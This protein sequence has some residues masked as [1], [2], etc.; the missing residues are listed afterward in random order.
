MFL[1]LS[2][3]GEVGIQ[4]AMRSIDGAIRVRGHA[5]SRTRNPHPN[6]QVASFARLDPEGERERAAVA[7]MSNQ[8]FNQMKSKTSLK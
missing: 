2:L 1:H 3:V 8:C 5:Q 6:P 7:E 4:P